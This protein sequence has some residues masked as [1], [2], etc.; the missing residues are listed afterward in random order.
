MRKPTIL[1]AAVVA[2]LTATVG[3]SVFM[4]SSAATTVAS[5]EAESGSP[6]KGATVIADAVASN[7]GA[8]SFAAM[9]VVTSP[10]GLSG[11]WSLDFRDEFDGN[12]IDYN[13]W[14]TGRWGRTTTGDTP[15][16]TSIEGAYFVSTNVSVSNGNL[17]LT[18]TPSVKTLNGKTYTYASGQVQSNGHYFLT[19]NTYIEARIKV[20]GCTGCWPAFWTVPNGQ[21]PPETDIFEFFNTSTAAQPKFNLHRA[22]G[23]QSGPKIYGETTVDYRDEYHTYGLYWNGTQY[24]SYLDGK[25]YDLGVTDP[26]TIPQFIILNLSMYDGNTPPSGSAMYVDWIRTWKPAL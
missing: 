24:I 25:A 4:Y 1:Q 5:Y 20:P 3:T 26:T 19:P 11:N 12:T 16:N 15:F 13:K 18:L 17:A 6:A 14:S 8:I 2:L 7:G 21:W 10:L 22:G 23:G 9:P